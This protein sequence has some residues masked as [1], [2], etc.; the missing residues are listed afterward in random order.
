MRESADRHVA[1]GLGEL[2]W[3][4]PVQEAIFARLAIVARHVAQGHGVA[5]RTPGE[6]Q[7]LA[8]QGA[9]DT[10]PGRAH[11]MRPARRSWPD[12]PRPDPRGIVRPARP[13][14]GSWAHHPHP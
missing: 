7:A 13:A 9:D 10:A 6:A 4:D 11:L 14:R 3:L 2:D 5:P 8:V 12:V 1:H